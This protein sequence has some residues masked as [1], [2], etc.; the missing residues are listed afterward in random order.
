MFVA[1]FATMSFA[2]TS[3][4]D[5]DDEPDVSNADV[6]GNYT[7]QFNGK[8][9]YYGYD[10]GFAGLKMS[11]LAFFNMED[12]YCLLLINA[13]DIPIKHDEVGMEDREQGE[14]SSLECQFVLEPFN[15]KTAK[16]GDVLSFKQVI[17]SHRK[18]SDDPKYLFDFNNYTYYRE[19][20]LGYNETKIYTWQSD[21]QGVVKFVSYTYD[22]D[23]EE[24]CLT[25]EFINVEKN[26]FIGDYDYSEFADKSKKGVFNGTISFHDS[27]C[28]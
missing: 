5:D 6:K 11:K 21:A 1:L 16:K 24:A 27:V 20:A 7:F 22:D 26:L 28:G 15:P 9:Y 17:A 10:Y 13:Q 12:D 2:F 3:C 19:A 4:S 8:T 14:S 23:T 18:D 25:L